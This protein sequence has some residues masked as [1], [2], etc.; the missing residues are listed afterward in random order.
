MPAALNTGTT[1]RL[2]TFP[3]L[4][5]PTQGC[6]P[7]ADVV[8]DVIFNFGGPA[9]PVYQSMTYDVVIAELRTAMPV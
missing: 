2:Q 9:Q 4:P 3:P 8:P 7:N 1:E 5:L 6:W